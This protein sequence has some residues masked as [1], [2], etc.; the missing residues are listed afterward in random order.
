M[1]NKSTRLAREISLLSLIICLVSF[2]GMGQ[3]AIQKELTTQERFAKLEHKLIYPFLKGSKMTGVVPVDFATNVVEKNQ[4]MKLIFDFTQGTAADLQSTNINPG[5]EEVIRVLNL[6]VAAG[7]EKKKLKVIIIFHSASLM[8]LLN[9]A[10]YQ[11]KYGVNNPNSDIIKQLH[12]ANVEMV[13]CGQSIHLRELKPD[14]FLSEMAFAISAKTTLSKYQ[15]LGY[16]LFAI[17]GH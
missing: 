9:D 7:I 6:H 17:A 15:N 2:L 5:L 1:K 4:G 11:A 3:T 16:I 14:Q 13:V 10:Y 12:A 8:S